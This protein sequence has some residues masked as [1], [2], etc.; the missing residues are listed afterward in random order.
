MEHKNNPFATIESS[1]EFMHLLKAAVAETAADVQEDIAEAQGGTDQRRAEALQLVDY[2]LHQLS[3][4]IAKSERLLKDL[5][6]LRKLILGEI[7]ASTLAATA[8]R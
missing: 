8:N 2:K 5:G 3:V 4:H 6:R 1:L 7:K